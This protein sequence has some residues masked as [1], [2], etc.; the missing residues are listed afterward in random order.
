MMTILPP[1]LIELIPAVGNIRV[2]E[3]PVVYTFLK[4]ALY[5]RSGLEIHIGD[6]HGKDG[7][8]T[9]PL[10][11]IVLP[12]VR[13]LIEIVVH[14]LPPF[15]KC[16]T[17]PDF[18]LCADSDL[19]KAGV[20]LILLENE[21]ANGLGADGS[22]GRIQNAVNGGCDISVYAGEFESEAGI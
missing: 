1:V 18:G 19:R 2:A 12:A 16:R 11:G 3:D 5:F 10:D 7:G 20:N 21:L 17:Y 13:Q 4:Y 14:N 22:G 8:V 9:V 15:W 6:P